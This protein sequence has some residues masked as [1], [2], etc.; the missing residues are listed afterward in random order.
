MESKHYWYI[1]GGIAAVIIIVLIIYFATRKKTEEPAPVND[2]SDIT[3]PGAG[4]GIGWDAASAGLSVLSEK[5]AQGQ[6]NIGTK[7]PNKQK[8][9]SAIRAKLPANQIAQKSYENFE[10]KASEQE[11]YIVYVWLVKGNKKSESDAKAVIK[12]YTIQ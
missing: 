1:G 9:L 3:K 10:E 8:Y 5:I 11:I 12:K 2:G 6:L 4:T 7:T